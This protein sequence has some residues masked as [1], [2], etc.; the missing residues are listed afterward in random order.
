[1]STNTSYVSID[2]IR[3]A[4]RQTQQSRKGGGLRNSHGRQRR[5]T[6]ARPFSATGDRR[7]RLTDVLDA[8]PTLFDP[9]RISV[10]EKYVTTLDALP[11]KFC[12]ANYVFLSKNNLSTLAGCEPYRPAEAS[13]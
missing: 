9:N 2:Q 13:H 1:M 11:E 6:A 7:I 12:A 8:S 5:I 3:R 10:V 4:Q